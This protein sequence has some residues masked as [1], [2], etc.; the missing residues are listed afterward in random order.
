MNDVR[1]RDLLVREL[2]ERAA[3][4]DGP[5]VGLEAVRA[6]ARRMRRRRAVGAAAVVAAVVAGVALPVGLVVSP[7]GP[8][9]DG[10]VDG[11]MEQP[12][13]T[14]PSGPAPT[15]RPDGTFPLTLDGVPRGEAPEV[16]YVVAGDR[17]LVTPTGSVE[18][19]EGYSQVIGYRDGWLAVDGGQNGY[20]TVVLDSDLD[21][22]RRSPGGAGIVTDADGSR[23]LHVRRDVRGGGS[24]VVDEPTTA[25]D[26]RAAVSWD[27][28]GGAVFV[29]VGYLDEETVVFQSSGEPD[30]TVAM[31]R[32]EDAPAT[33]P[34]RGFL[35]VTAASEANGL[36]AGRTSWSPRGSC[37]GV[38]EPDEST[39]TMVWETCQ[40][41]LF[42]FSPDGRYVLA[43]PPD[44][45]VWGPGGLSVLE[46]GSWEPV[47]RLRP[48]KGAP[49]QVSQATWED[50]DTV[51][52]VMVEGAEFGIVRVE[53]SGRL[54][55]TGD[56][57]RSTNMSLPLWLA[58]VPRG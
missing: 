50:A 17:R 40:H 11:P 33:V 14:A 56:T 47:V 44:Y 34:L 37:W 31:G 10:P 8:P 48:E 25:G 19:P 35:Q 53:L 51:V 54:E 3:A 58:E 36:V 9:M 29:P 55:L 4:L 32:A 41:S 46:V 20:E 15:P 49:V 43:G 5:G 38:M 12:S 7:D 6:S 39:S 18:L 22:V 57:H 52:A 23:V 28:P 2:R 30:T 24:V 21:V 42:G 45:D 16:S 13:V 27:A 26:D 1:E